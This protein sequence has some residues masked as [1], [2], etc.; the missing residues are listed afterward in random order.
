M[1]APNSRR[2]LDN[3]IRRKYGLGDE[4]VIEDVDGAAVWANELIRT[5]ASA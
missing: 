5:I 4:Y 3:A 1:N 2:N